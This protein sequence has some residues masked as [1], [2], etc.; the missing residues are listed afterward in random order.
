[1]LFER[2]S[3]RGAMTLSN[4]ASEPQ[5]VR[6]RLT[7]H[8]PDLIQAR[9]LQPGESWQAGTPERSTSTRQP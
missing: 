1:M 9:L 7:S 2:M 4:E 8:G 6:L 5:P 3:E